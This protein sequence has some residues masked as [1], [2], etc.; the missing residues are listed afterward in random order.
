MVI[1][2][3]TDKSDIK[4]RLSYN[5]KQKKYFFKTLNNRKWKECHF[6]RK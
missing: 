6:H 1:K 4:I 2:K 3:K 5:L